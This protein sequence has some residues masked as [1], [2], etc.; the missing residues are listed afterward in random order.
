MKASPLILLE[1]SVDTRAEI[2]FNEYITNSLQQYV[3]AYGNENGFEKW[4][5]QLLQSLERIQRRLGG[6]RYKHINSIMQS[7]I[8][9]QRDSDNADRHR[10]WINS[11]L[12]DYYDPMY[13]YQLTKKTHRVVFQ[14]NKAEIRDYLKQHYDLY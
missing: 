11:L 2:I 3:D 14:G 10:E 1:E 9:T 5:E 4:A 6:D 12:V 7:A 8:N 13:D